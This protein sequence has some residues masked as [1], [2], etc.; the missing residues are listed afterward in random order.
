MTETLRIAIPSMGEGGLEGER[1]GHF[2]HCDCFTIVDVDHGEIASVTVVENPPHVQGGCL[3]PVELLASHR[4]DALVVAGM[5]ARPLEGFNNVGI[6][7]Y[8][9]NTTP[10]I[11]DVVS[12]LLEGGLPVMES[13]HTCSGH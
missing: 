12:M 11:G 1:S 5:G 9:E 10:G 4:V 8:F 2:G 6:D 13:R 7:V 3:R